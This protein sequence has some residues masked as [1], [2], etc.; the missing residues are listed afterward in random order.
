MCEL[1]VGRSEYKALVCPVKEPLQ[2]FV[3]QQSDAILASHLA[4]VLHL[5]PKYSSRDGDSVNLE[6][7]MDGHRRAGHFVQRF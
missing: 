7:P 6:R 5:A 2:V 1:C 3:T 4:G